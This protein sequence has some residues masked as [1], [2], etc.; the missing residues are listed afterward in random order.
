MLG[1]AERIFK[2]AES[3]VAHRHFSEKKQLDAN[4]K[5]S[6]LNA[7]LAK[8]NMK[9]KGRGQIFAIISFLSSMSVSSYAVYV[10]AYWVAGTIGGIAI[11]S[12]VSAFL[13]AQRNKSS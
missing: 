13:S 2:M 5:I 1:S 7:D 8:S 6:E 11:A 10:S 3:E 9:L 12:I 4:I